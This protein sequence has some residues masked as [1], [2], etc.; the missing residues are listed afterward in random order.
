MRAVSM[1]ATEMVAKLEGVE[2]GRQVFI[3]YLAGRPPTDRAIREATKADEAY[4]VP[5][6]KRWLQGRFESLRITKKG[7]PV[8][9]LFSTTRYNDQDPGAEGHYR[10]INPALGILLS[11]EVL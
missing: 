8:M 6:P 4:D 11:L 5:I 9:T 10:S 2:K 3:S 7:E 1:T